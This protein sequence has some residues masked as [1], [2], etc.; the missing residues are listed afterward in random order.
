MTVL[1]GIRRHAE[2][3]DAEEGGV[4]RRK[5]S[6]RRVVGCGTRRR[7]G[8]RRSGEGRVGKDRAVSEGGTAT[9]GDGRVGGG[10]AGVGE[11]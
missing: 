6:W 5:R 8:L 11:G 9:G 7:G 3:E 1:G 2:R 4:I 10:R